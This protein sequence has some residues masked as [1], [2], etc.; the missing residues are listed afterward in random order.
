MRT[1]AARRRRRARVPPRAT[2]TI[3]SVAARC[4]LSGSDGVTAREVADALTKMTC[5]RARKSLMEGDVDHARERS[6]YEAMRAAAGRDGNGGWT[7]RTSASGTRADGRGGR[8]GGSGD[9]RGDA[10]D[11]I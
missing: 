2:E 7:T 3:L 4:I 8:A 10:R 1:I 6:A 5:E 11:D 9:A